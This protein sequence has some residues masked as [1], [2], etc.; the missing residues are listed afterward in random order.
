MVPYATPII[1]ALP[2]KSLVAHPTLTSE[3]GRHRPRQRKTRPAITMLHLM[4]GSMYP[5]STSRPDRKRD[6]AMPRAR[7]EKKSPELSVMPICRAYMAM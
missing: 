3:S 2:K 4:M 5:R 6:E 1:S 7:H